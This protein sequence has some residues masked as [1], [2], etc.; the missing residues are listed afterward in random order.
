[1]ADLLTILETMEHRWMRAWV[2]RDKRVL[3]ALTS[4][5]FRLVVSSK[6][7]V[8]LDAASWLNAATTRYACRGYRFGDVY[9]RNLGAMAIF[10]TRC[11]IDATM[12]G[13]DWSG[14]MWVSD[15][16]RKS[17]VRRNWRLIERV[18]SR[19]D[20]DPQVPT[21]IRSLQLWR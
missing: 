16:W 2:S 18:L 3:K 8:I 9:A 4:P 20:D 11:E 10:A 13:E 1:M 12:D 14:E 6:P 17:K 7:P 15:I 21:A 5:Q 19:P